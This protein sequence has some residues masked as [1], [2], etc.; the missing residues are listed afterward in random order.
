MNAITNAALPTVA[1]TPFEGGFYAGRFAL[2]G[3]EY[4]LI[5]APKASGAHERTAWGK[6]GQDIEGTRSFNDG[7]ANTEAMA[8]AGSNLA[9]WALELNIDGFADWYIP[10]RDELELLYRHFKPTT[11]TNYT[12]RHGDNPS[13]LPAGYPYTEE[14]PAQTT[15]A[16]FQEG[17]E[18]AFEDASYW[19]STQYSPY[20]AWIQYF[21]GGGQSFDLKDHE[22]RAV[23][24]RRFKVTP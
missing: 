14:S 5:L 9:Q 13:S 1:G 15:L 7:R 23:A 3:A 20:G 21:A 4:A 6:Y 22:R 16:A 8:A 18:E 12:W 19:A 17:G 2:D 24:V 10:S 11:E